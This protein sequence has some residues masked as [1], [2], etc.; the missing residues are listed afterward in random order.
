MSQVNPNCS[1]CGRTEIDPGKFVAGPNRFICDECIE[2]VSLALLDFSGN[3]NYKFQTNTQDSVRCD[4]CAKRAKD[5]WRL[6]T[7]SGKNICSECVE[8]CN[9]ILG[10]TDEANE[11]NILRAAKLRKLNKS[12]LPSVVGHRSGLIIST[13][14]R[15][16]RKVL[17]KIF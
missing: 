11:V 4:F 6:L 3:D 7:E 12:P 9:D 15:F 16:L 10:D 5:V 17:E 8:I 1:F 13:Q 2:Q 14:N